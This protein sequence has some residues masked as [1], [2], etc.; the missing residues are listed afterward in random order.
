MSMGSASADRVLLVTSRASQ[1]LHPGLAHHAKNLACAIGL[2]VLS[3]RTLVVREF[4]ESTH[5]SG[6]SS[7]SDINLRQLFDLTDVAKRFGVCVH[8]VKSDEGAELRSR[9]TAQGILARE[10]GKGASLSWASLLGSTPLLWLH[11]VTKYDNMYMHPECLRLGAQLEAQLRVPAHSVLPPSPRFLAAARAIAKQLGNFSGVHVRQGDKLQ[12]NSPM[13]QVPV[14]T[15]KHLYASVYAMTRPAGADTVRR[16]L[17][18][19]TDAPSL[20]CNSSAYWTW[21]L[22]HDYQLRTVADFWPTVQQQLPLV[23][24]EASKLRVCRTS[25]LRCRTYALSWLETLVQSRAWRFLGT[26]RSGLSH[27]VYVQRMRAV[28]TD[29]ASGIDPRFYGILS[30]DVGAAP[31]SGT[32]ASAWEEAYLN[33]GRPHLGL[34]NA[35][36]TAQAAAARD[37]ATRRVG[38][39]AAEG[40]D[41]PLQPRA[42]QQGLD[43]IAASCA[44][45]LLQGGMPSASV[46]PSAKPSAPRPAG[47]ANTSATPLAA[48]RVSLGLGLALALVFA[49]LSHGAQRVS[50]AGDSRPTELN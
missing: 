23:A 9:Y 24:R 10:W 30:G 41:Q 17:L 43:K 20:V 42:R 13:L 21:R 40:D 44:T 8:S 32:W 50:A 14:V 5:F 34:V 26:E 39:T 27:Q 48:G 1:W 22:A 33:A 18:V 2:A 28:A 31:S 29:E 19:S 45:R 49:A 46:R 12:E 6:R 3:N 16:V 47:A 15:P 4:L 11:D 25:K 35:E 7:P 38:L 36:W 37:E